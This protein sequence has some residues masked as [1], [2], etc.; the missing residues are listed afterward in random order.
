MN[1]LCIV[2]A[3]SLA[4]VQAQGDVTSCNVQGSSSKCTFDPSQLN[5]G[6][7]STLQSS[8]AKSR[9][10]KC[11]ALETKNGWYGEQYSR[12]ARDANFI[13]RNDHNGLSK[14]FGSIRNGSDICSI[15]PNAIGAGEIDMYPGS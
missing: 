2:V 7:R 14:V 1:L 13:H 10:I 3:T 4:F 6:S 15:R 8:D 9:I 11:D 5:L 12:N